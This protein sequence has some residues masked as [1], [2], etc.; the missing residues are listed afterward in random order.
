MATSSTPPRRVP[1]L[2]APAGGVDALRAA[3]NNGA[4]AVYLG[5]RE[6]NARRGAENFD[7]GS[8]ADACRYAHLRGARV[9]LTANVLV[10]DDE[11]GA[12]LA[13]VAE[14]WAVGVD[15]VIVQD[16]G[17]LAE[18]RRALPELR[19]HAST[20]IGAHNTATV[21]ALAALGAARVTLA[22]ELTVAEVA[23]LAA[24]GVEVESF[25]HGALCFAYS[26]Q[27][28]LSSVVGGR[29][30]NRGLCAQPCRLPY[31]LLDPSG[32]TAAEAH[33]LSTRDLCGLEALPR[34]IA[35]GVAALKIEG[36]MKSPEYVALVTGV[37]RAAL[38]R[39]AADPD[40][41][42]VLPAEEAVLAEAF[43]RGFSTAY[44]DGIRDDRM[45]SVKRPNNRGVPVGRIVSASGAEA[46][47]AFDRAVESADTI[48]VWT[49]SGRFAQRLSEVA[50]GG[51]PA[52]S[53]PAGSRATVRIEGRAG[54]GDR[55]VRV[56]NAALLDAARRTFADGAPAS[57]VPAD[58]AVTLRIGEPLRVA[59]TARGVTGE[60]S[61]PP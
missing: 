32:A 15:A 6:L 26:G 48:E 20:Q 60:A 11:L 17:L 52:R 5:M 37:Y 42:E 25:V 35:A 8:L 9:Y 29:S 3:V 54:K 47:I 21:R 43:S 24:H 58:V 45:M 49:G 19:V 7:A 1:E 38:D 14:A 53:V 50:V 34:L 10:R 51:V 57:L 46:V 31:A 30:A 33:L 23:V 44:L 27:C 18:V 13:L 28:L 56:A 2:L 55:V 22:R 40:A 36:R 16:L 59:L 39:A 41:F 12:A 61:G 4:D